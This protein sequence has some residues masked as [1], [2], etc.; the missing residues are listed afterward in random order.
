M[1]HDIDT[2]DASV[3]RL[4]VESYISIPEQKSRLLRALEPICTEDE[5]IVTTVATFR[6]FHD[7]SDDE[8][9][10]VLDAMSDD[11]LE[12][13]V[14]DLYDAWASQCNHAAEELVYVARKKENV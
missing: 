12:Q 7:T 10:A 6:D 11:E 4:L 9:Q 1:T 3:L 14:P 8:T 13:W 2:D 5:R